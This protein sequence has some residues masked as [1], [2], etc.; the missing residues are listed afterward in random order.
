MSE[1]NY[2]DA[3][4][5]QS[6][7]PQSGGRETFEVNGWHKVIITDSKGAPN[8]KNT[9]MLWTAYIKCM[10]GPDNGKTIDHNINVFHQSAQAQDIG[11]REFSGY[12]HALGEFK[13]IDNAAS[14]FRNKP[15]MVRTET[16]EEE[17]QNTKGETVK[18]RKTL[19]RECARVGDP[20]ANTAG[21]GAAASLP[22][23]APAAAPS[24][25]AEKPIQAGWGAP[26]PGA[27]EAPAEASSAPWG[28]GAAQTAGGE[29]KKAPWAS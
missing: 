29:E 20:K 8:S 22:T 1:Q 3:V 17:F 25:A 2:F 21:N 4:N 6:I 15:F 24:E 7:E 12:C 23:P 10:E 18:A 14:N 27:G 5:W 26:P 9:G 19:V 28:A 11:Q 13:P 16:V